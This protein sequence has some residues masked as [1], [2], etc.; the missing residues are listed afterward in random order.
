MFKAYIMA[1]FL[2]G[3]VLLMAGFRKERIIFS[4]SQHVTVIFTIVAFIY[5]E[6]F[7]FIL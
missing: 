2:F 7:L 6:V 5:V 3:Y 4:C 1:F